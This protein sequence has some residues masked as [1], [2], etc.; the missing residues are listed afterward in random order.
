[1]MAV[2]VQRLSEHA[3]SVL[4]SLIAIAIWLFIA[5]PSTLQ[6]I[7]APKTQQVVGVP[8]PPMIHSAAQIQLMLLGV[9]GAVCFL[10][11]VLSLPGLRLGR[12]GSLIALLAPW[13]YLAVRDRE[14]GYGVGLAGMLY[15]LVII[16]IYF[17]S[18]PL[19]SLRSIAHLTAITAVLSIG[20]ALLRPSSALYTSQ[21]G[22]QIAED[23][24]I[25]PWGLLEGFLSQPNNLGQLLIIGFPAV[26]LLRRGPLRYLYTGVIGLALIWTASRSTIYAA[27]IGV[28]V[29]LVCLW[30][31]RSSPTVRRAVS[32]LS[33]LMMT[34]VLV[35]L[36]LLTTDPEDFSNRG[37]IWH[38]SLQAWTG[39]PWFGLGA[40]W[41]TVIGSTS[42]NLGGSVFHGHNQ[43]VQA[44]VTGGV[45]LV[46]LLALLVGVLMLAASRFAARGDIFGTVY[47]TALLGSCWLE[48]SMRFVDSS[49]FIGV[50]AVPTAVLLFAS[51]RDTAARQPEAIEL[52]EPE[53]SPV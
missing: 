15:P 26:L 14:L 37:Y 21:S 13:I 20:M 28:L 5:I 42:A 12:G 2:G 34:V 22:I 44:L 23:K 50:V 4:T 1:M 7:G 48:V 36:P 19:S 49:S 18:P 47:L 43:F 53:L 41:Y 51:D 33:V 16:A 39:S 10:A 31:R 27:G 9:L 8:A 30:A 25:L 45:V 24:Q 38:I 46:A 32:A 11:V 40:N 52:A 29:T 3:R 6:S 17:L 35:A